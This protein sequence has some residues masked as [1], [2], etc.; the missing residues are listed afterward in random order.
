[1]CKQKKG[2]GIVLLENHTFKTCIDI[3]GNIQNG[4]FSSC[5][6]EGICS[7]CHSIIINES[8]YQSLLMRY[9]FEKMNV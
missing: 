6:H 3:P 4:I 7:Y 8:V 9:L 5:R 1:M 2:H